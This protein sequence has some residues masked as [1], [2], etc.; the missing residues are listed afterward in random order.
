[1]HAGLPMAWRFSSADLNGAWPWGDAVPLQVFR[2][3]AD[4][5]SLSMTELRSAG[6][7]PVELGQLAKSARDRLA[8]IEKDD[9][10]ELFSLRISGR[11][12][13]WCITDRNVMRVLWYDP[14][15]EVCPA[16]LRHT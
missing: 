7:H 10:D 9:I 8:A 1:M 15:H 12:R 11:E 6:S 4:F 13:I 3:L 2:K 5:E 16:L 14:R